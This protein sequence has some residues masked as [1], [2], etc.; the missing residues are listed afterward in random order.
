MGGEEGV[1]GGDAL[2][3]GGDGLTSVADKTEGCN[4]GEGGQ[5]WQW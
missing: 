4:G 1:V 2:R 3:G 5:V